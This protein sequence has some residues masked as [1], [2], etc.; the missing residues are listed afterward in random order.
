M[1]SLPDVLVLVGERC[2]AYST[3]VCHPIP[4]GVKSQPSIHLLS[5]PLTILLVCCHINHF[6]RA[7][8][9]SEAMTRRRKEDRRAGLAS[10]G[11]WSDWVVSSPICGHRG[12][13]ARSGG[14]ER[15]NSSGAAVDICSDAPAWV[16]RAERA[17]DGGVVDVSRA[18]SVSPSAPRINAQR[19]ARFDL[20][21]T[22]KCLPPKKLRREIQ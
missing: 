21:N 3:E 11:I 20:Y 17:A 2:G 18:R 19:V 15:R 7:A 16:Q 8:S 13:P 4:Y 1:A 22:R 5:A 6:R 14:P 12:V 10:R 9:C